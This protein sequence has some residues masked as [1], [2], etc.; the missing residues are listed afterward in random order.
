MLLGLRA[1]S[2]VAVAILLDILAVAVSQ[3]GYTESERNY[4]VDE[5]D[6]VMGYS[7]YGAWYHSPYGDWCAMFVSFCLHYAG[8]WDLPANA[9]PEAMRLEWETAHLYP[10]AA[11]HTPV[12]QFMSLIQEDLS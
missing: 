1:I 10:P 12:L 11:E 6:V 2:V 8:A 5:N 3:L 9:G 4:I 7:R